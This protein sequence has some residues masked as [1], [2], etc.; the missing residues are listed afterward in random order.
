MQPNCGAL[1]DTQCYEVSLQ[2]NGRPARLKFDSGVAVTLINETLWRELG[3]PRL[4]ES[5][6]VCRSF[7][8]QQ[9]S[10]KGQS[11]VNVVYNGKSSRLP[12]LI[13]R[14]GDNVLGRPW[15]RALQ[16]TDLNALH[17]AESTP[18]NVL[19][20]ATDQ[21]PDSPPPLAGRRALVVQPTTTDNLVH[22]DQH[23]KLRG[24]TVGRQG[25][26]TR[27]VKVDGRSDARVRRA[28][29]LRLATK[30][31]NSTITTTADFVFED[32]KH[33]E[34]RNVKLPIDDARPPNGPL[35]SPHTP[36]PLCARRHRARECRSSNVLRLPSDQDPSKVRPA[37]MDTS[38]Q[39]AIIQQLKSFP[40]ASE[41]GLGHRKK[42]KAHL[43]L[44]EGA[45]PPVLHEQ[46]LPFAVRREQPSR[47]RCA[48]T[49]YVACCK[50]PSRCCAC[51]CCE[52]SSRSSSF[53]RRFSSPSATPATKSFPSRRPRRALNRKLP[54]VRRRR[55]RFVDPLADR[56]RV[57]RR[58]SDRHAHRPRPP[59]TPS[60]AFSSSGEECRGVRSV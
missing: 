10:I 3:R 34:R 16:I 6:V 13:T 57:P 30:S 46:P 56:H 50:R 17:I 41:P 59:S 39:P 5:T 33:S 2:I 1:G 43:Q 9:I 36:S 58:S 42:L 22:F 8:S 28:D 32:A 11:T 37:T 40:Q 53:S 18:I 54:E 27:N 52:R 23:A 25:D 26:V 60:A 31:Y 19:R 29:Q 4:E 21:S 45:R 14:Q 7:T 12:M 51:C 24:S 38:D 35:L 55:S 20:V 47:R 15:I 48:H 49:R 44:R